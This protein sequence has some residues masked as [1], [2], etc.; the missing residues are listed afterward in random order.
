MK[1]YA[2]ENG[3]PYDP[4]D[5]P[6]WSVVRDEDGKTFSIH[7]F[8]VNIE[9]GEE[10]ECEYVCELTMD[11]MIEFISRLNKVY[12]GGINTYDDR[13]FNLVAVM[14]RPGNNPPPEDFGGVQVNV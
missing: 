6:L 10:I 1:V 8:G 3:D 11:E 14:A 13:M 2:L 4:Q 7:T 12:F 5:T 9:K